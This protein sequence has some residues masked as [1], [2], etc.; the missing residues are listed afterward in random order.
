MTRMALLAVVFGAIGLVSAGVLAPAATGRAFQG[1]LTAPANG[2]PFGGDVVGSYRIDVRGERTMIH[3]EVVLQAPDGYTF[4]GWL[5]DLQTG[6]KLS[7]GE[8]EHGTLKFQ[9][10]MVN[11][12]TYGILVITREPVG[13]L[14]PNPATPVAGALLP[15]PFGQ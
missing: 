5:V 2:A 8:L 3:A 12:W 13:D 10:R 6:Y 15:S 11:P 7:L 4:E 14:D 9:E 1:D